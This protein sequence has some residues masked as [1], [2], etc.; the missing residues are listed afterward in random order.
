MDKPI[1]KV[2]AK[3]REHIWCVLI[4]CGILI[5]GIMTFAWVGK[6][7]Q[8]VGYVSFASAIVSIALGII[9]I[10]YSYYQNHYSQQ[11]IDKMSDLVQRIGERTEA[12]GKGVEGLG[13]R[14]EGLFRAPSLS[15][16]TKDLKDI[17]Q[18]KFNET[19]NLGRYS[20]VSLTILCAIGRSLELKKPINFRELMNRIAEVQSKGTPPNLYWWWYSA[21]LF[22]AIGSLKTVQWK[23][24]EKVAPI[25]QIEKLPDDFQ[26]TV[27]AETARRIEKKT[28]DAHLLEEMISTVDAYFSSDDK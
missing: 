15:A 10:I 23:H 20:N 12:V 28:K 18:L 6:D 3:L 27:Q 22:S 5:T 1:G 25:T 8:I 19:F 21:G 7:N 2:T 16:Q 11:N 14:F 13:E 4:I 9:V 26:A 24:I 17:P